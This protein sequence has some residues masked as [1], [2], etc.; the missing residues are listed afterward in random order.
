MEV[1]PLAL[2]VN[3]G[4]ELGADIGVES[5]VDLGV[6]GIPPYPQLHP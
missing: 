1:D 4:V 6:G 3:L 2:G 5:G